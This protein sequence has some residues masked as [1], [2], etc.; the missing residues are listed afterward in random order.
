MEEMNVEMI[1]CV[2]DLN[3]FAKKCL[4]NPQTTL[5]SKSKKK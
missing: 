1:T 4:P 5:W 3:L 2:Y